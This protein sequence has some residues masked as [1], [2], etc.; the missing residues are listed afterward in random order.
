VANAVV[1]KVTTKSVKML[2]SHIESILVIRFCPSV[3]SARFP[4]IWYNCIDIVIRL[5]ARC[6]LV[7][8]QQCIWLRPSKAQS[9]LS[10][11]SG[12]GLQRHKL[13]IMQ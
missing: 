3:V 12:C 10:N 7:F 6:E 8:P 9:F 13:A 5:L 11:A 2:N 1:A 4:K